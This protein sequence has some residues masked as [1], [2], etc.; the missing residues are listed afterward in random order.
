MSSKYKFTVGQSVQINND[1]NSKNVGKFG[2][3]KRRFEDGSG[4]GRSKV[5]YVIDLGENLTA[6]M[7][8][9]NLTA[10]ADAPNVTEEKNAPAYFV[11]ATDGSFVSGA[12]SFK[13][14]SELA[15]E[16]Q[17]ATPDSPNYY[18]AKAI[19]KTSTP[20]IVVDMVSI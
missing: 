3:I 8:Q 6:E 4:W 14:A 9:S 12:L 19:Q 16:K 20:K 11:I 5:K 10:V 17:L 1:V 18:V 13:K 2:T 7:I 15:K